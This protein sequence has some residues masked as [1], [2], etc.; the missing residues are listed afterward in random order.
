[1]AACITSQISYCP[2]VCMRHS[3]TLNNKINKLTTTLPLT[4]DDRRLA[5]E[6]LLNKDTS[7][8]IHKRNLQVH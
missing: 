6:V 8:T 7:V 1:M 4:S 3:T 2:L 5:F